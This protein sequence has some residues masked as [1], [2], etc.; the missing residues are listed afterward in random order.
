MQSMT[1]P[2][3][4]Y[5]VN[6]LLCLHYLTRYSTSTQAL[7]YGIY[8]CVG[9]FSTHYHTFNMQRQYIGA[10]SISAAKI[11]SQSHAK[12]S[13]ETYFRDLKGIK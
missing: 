6:L 10:V 8:V 2:W 3:H 12:L 4:T 1:T 7:H 5:S 11:S 13:L 9:S